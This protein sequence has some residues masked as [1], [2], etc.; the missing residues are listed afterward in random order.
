MQHL[1]PPYATEDDMYEALDNCA[2]T[3]N[4]IYAA[5]DRRYGASAAKMSEQEMAHVIREILFDAFTTALEAVTIYK[6]PFDA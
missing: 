4:E 6:V 5:I 2:M 3:E 1:L